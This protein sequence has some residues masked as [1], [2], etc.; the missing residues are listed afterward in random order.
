MLT[1]TP[2][3]CAWPTIRCLG[4][5][6]WIQTPKSLKAVAEKVAQQQFNV[7]KDPS[8]CA[9]LYI[10]LG[11][12]ST[13][14]A[15]FKARSQQKLFEFFARSFTDIKNQQAAEKNAYVCMSKL[16]FSYAAG[17][18]LLA[19]QPRAALDVLISKARDWHLALF[20]AR[21][22]GDDPLLEWFWQQLYA[23]AGS[24]GDSFPQLWAANLPTALH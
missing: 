18:F 23:L 9:L 5:P 11:R 3:D 8:S 16:N 6:L 13:L 1:A 14:A 2:Q 15:L 21:L 10:S 17:F 24:Q 19:G 20:V 22:L 4:L 7:H 12:K